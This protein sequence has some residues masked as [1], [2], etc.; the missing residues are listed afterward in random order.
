MNTTD[1]KLVIEAAL[2]CAQ[3]PMPIPQLRRLF[4]DEI[5][6][7]TVR[8]LL[9]DL[10]QDWLGKGLSLV[11]LATGWRFQSTP[12]MAQYLVRLSP[13]KTPRYSRATLETLTIIAY[14]QPVTRGDIEE[15][16]GVTVSSQLIK[17][18]EDRGWIE[19][20]GQ[21]DVLGRP[22]LFG[23]TKQFL[24]DLGLK[25]LNGLPE[26]ISESGEVL[27]DAQN[28]IAFEDP[29]QTAIVA[30]GGAVNLVETIEPEATELTLIEDTKGQD[31]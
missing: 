21:K 17:T 20:V 15:I 29:E 11:Q 30:A 5:G 18:L 10:R 24:N 23:T 13:E 4:E 7:D 9:D 3:E 14:R 22:S 26:I 6:A 1:A 12:E 28:V 8:T 31:Q 16:R 25:S 27:E 2:L 19:V